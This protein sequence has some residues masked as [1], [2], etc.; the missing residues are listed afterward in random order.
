MKLYQVK[1]S[2]LIRL[3]LPLILLLVSVEGNSQTHVPKLNFTELEKYLHQSND[4]TYVV[5]F[6]ATW[7]GPCVKEL[8][9]FEEA[10][11]YEFDQPVKVLLVS[12]D[13]PQHYESSLL[14]FIKRKNIKSDVIYLDDG[15][16]HQWI[17]KVDPKWSGAIPATLVYKGNYRKFYEESF[18]KEQL[19]TAVNEAV[20]GEQ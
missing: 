18:S 9:H 1:L 6:W 15:K 20:N 5:N 17:P 3:L 11:E 8:P 2:L 16:A 4:T 14:P 7:C 13:F 10:N 12:L 19:F